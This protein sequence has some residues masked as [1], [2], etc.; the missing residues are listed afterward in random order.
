MCGRTKV[1]VDEYSYVR[2]NADRVNVTPA[3]DS[4]WL[5]SCDNL[6]VDVHHITSVLSA[7]SWSR[8]ELIQPDMWLTHSVI[9]DDRV[10]VAAGRQKPY[11]WLSSA[12]WCSK[13]PCSETI[14]ARPAVYMMKSI[15][16]RTDPCGAPQMTSIINGYGTFAAA[17]DML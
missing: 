16:P 6:R 12:Y 15:G 4:G 1:T 13:R 8:F 14:G 10:E 9:S 11:I 17:P 2:N 5:G 3:T 7:L